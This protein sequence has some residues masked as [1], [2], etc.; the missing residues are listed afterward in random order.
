MT[1]LVQNSCYFKG[2]LTAIS[3]EAAKMVGRIQQ[4]QPKDG[5]L[6]KPFLSDAERLDF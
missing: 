6:S 1:V 2:V 5:A 4:M 3:R